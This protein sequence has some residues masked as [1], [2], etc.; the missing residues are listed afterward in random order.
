MTKRPDAAPPKE[1][2]S[3]DMPGP[4]SHELDSA[5]MPSR[6]ASL[7]GQQGPAGNRTAA[8]GGP[9]SDAA[10]KEGK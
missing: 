9:P 8:H 10:Q 4:P 3:Y 2:M 1:V 6:H 5:T 7:P